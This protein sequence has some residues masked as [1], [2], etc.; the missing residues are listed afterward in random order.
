MGFLIYMV[1]ERIRNWTSYQLLR[2]GRWGQYGG[3]L[4]VRGLRRWW[5]L[6]APWYQ[7]LREQERP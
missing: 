5:K 2:A 4:A 3:A 6:S 1:D 7:E